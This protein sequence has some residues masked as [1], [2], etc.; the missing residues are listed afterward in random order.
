MSSDS[1]TIEE[2]ARWIARLEAEIARLKKEN[3]FLRKCLEVN[4][5]AEKTK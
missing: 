5:I 3:A 1:G 4:G 2:Y